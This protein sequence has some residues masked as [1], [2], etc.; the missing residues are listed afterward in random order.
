MS[1]NDVMVR[2]ID[3]T[4][5]NKENDGVVRMSIGN[6]STPAKRR[7][8]PRGWSEAV[9]KESGTTYY[10]NTTTQETTWQMPEGFDP[11][12]PGQPGMV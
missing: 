6:S 4:V 3:V 7:P 12:E 5:A 8:A 2:N 9:H 1:A 11:N 10:Y